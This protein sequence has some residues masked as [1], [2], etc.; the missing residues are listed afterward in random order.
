MT[1]RL[2]LSLLFA[3]AAGLAQTQSSDSAVAPAPDSVLPYPT[4]SPGKAV[5]LSFLI[6]GGGQV[7][8]RNYW[9][10]PLIA[11]AEIALSYLTFRE[12]SAARTAL[13]S[14]DT[15]TYILRRDRGTTYLFFTGAVI[16]FS[17]ADA[18]VSAQFFGF[19]EQMRLSIAPDRLG[20]IVALGR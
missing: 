15:S 2:A 14:N 9:K 16:A 4:R 5:L 13:N 12:Y 1:F 7:Y 3:L 17:M 6:P 19:R 10:V 11:P 18:Y 8:T 20:L